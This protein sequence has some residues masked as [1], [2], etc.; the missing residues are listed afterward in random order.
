MSPVKSK[1]MVG[2][3]AVAEGA[4]VGTLAAVAI[5]AAVGTVGAAG[6][7]AVGG[8]GVTEGW[9]EGTSVA[10]SANVGSGIAGVAAEAQAARPIAD[11]INDTTNPARLT[12][13]TLY[14]SALLWSR[15]SRCFSSPSISA[16][17][18]SSGQPATSLSA[19]LVQATACA[20]SGACH[21]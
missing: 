21:S 20:R 16:R 19:R 6:T 12:L 3:V 15:S 5:A 8:A 1:V 14:F 2:G 11:R 13:V 17:R 4:E 9:G 10:G 18:Q 7:F